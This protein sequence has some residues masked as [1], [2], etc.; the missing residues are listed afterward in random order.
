M[1]MQSIKSR[2]NA[3]KQGNLRNEFRGFV[4]HDEL[5]KIVIRLDVGTREAVATSVRS[6]DDHGTAEYRKF[7]I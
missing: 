6:K 5:D 7:A 1:R 4:D 2:A 3:C